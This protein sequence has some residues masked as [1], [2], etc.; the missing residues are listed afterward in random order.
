MAQNS[1]DF[2]GE[3]AAL[4]KGSKGKK[5][6][7]VKSKDDILEDIK[8]K[9]DTINYELIGTGNEKEKDD[10]KVIKGIGPWIEQKLFALGIF[11]YHQIALFD[12]PTIQKVTDA[13]EAFPGRIQRDDWIG[14]AKAFTNPPRK[15][16]GG[17]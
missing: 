4:K 17:S 14:Q 5:K 8:S 13:L 12:E 11:N 6:T 15:D 16:E 9:R 2:L 3:I 7:P 10:L 1:R